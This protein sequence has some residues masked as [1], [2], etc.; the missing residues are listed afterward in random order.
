MHAEPFSVENCLRYLAERGYSMQSPDL[1]QVAQLSADKRA[2]HSLCE[3]LNGVYSNGIHIGSIFLILGVSF[4]GTAIPIAGKFI[5]VIGRYPF[6]FVIAKSAATGVLLSVSTIHLIHEGMMAF[7]EPCMNSTLKKYE[8]VYFLFALIAVLLM[9][10]LDIQ[11]GEVAERWMKAQLAAEAEAGAMADASNDDK[12]QQQDQE[13]ERGDDGFAEAEVGRPAHGLD[14]DAIECDAMVGSASGVPDEPT[15]AEQSKRGDSAT[16]LATVELQ[17][18]HHTHS[19]P[20]LGH[21]K[22]GECDAHGHQHLNVQPPRDM[23]SIRRVIA[24]ICME[25]G[26]TLHSVFVGLAIGLTTDSE[27]KPLLVALVFHQLFE[28]MSLGSRLADADFAGSLEIVLAFVFSVSAPVGM[29][30]ATIA[31]SVSR[32]A[33]SG[34]GFVTLMGVLDSLCG[35]ILLYLAFTLLLGDFAADLRHHCA[36]GLPNRLWKKIGMFAALW[37][38]MGVMALV[39]NW[40]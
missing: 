37:I 15:T 6:V 13:Q 31:V 1:R 38:G 5:P 34:S 30:A 4:L 40:L 16:E 23:G 29:A 22:D 2:T 18:H 12:Q 36:D 32:N 24:A 7:R 8:P 14:L 39:G 25:F 20:Q 27:L 3:G 21:E 17:A 28:G 10:L 33:M 11:L 26:V 19:H 9:Q 35:G